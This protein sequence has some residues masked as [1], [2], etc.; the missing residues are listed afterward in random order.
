MSGG[1]SITTNPVA[2]TIL[3]LAEAAGAGKSIS[4]EDAARALAGDEPNWQR[5]LPRVRQAAGDLARAGTI[6]ILRKGKPVDDLDAVKG[7][8]RY[9]LKI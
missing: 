1:P 8:V 7:V 6:E 4:P 9:R 2:A 3:R 5:L